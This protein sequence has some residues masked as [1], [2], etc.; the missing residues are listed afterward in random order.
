MK[1]KYIAIAS[2]AAVFFVTS[3]SE[4]YDIYPEEYSKVLRFKDGGLQNITVYSPQDVTE[5]PIVIQKGGTNPSTTATAKVRLMTEEEFSTYLSESGAGYTYLPTNCYS[6]GDGQGSEMTVD[7]AGK[8]GYQKIGVNLYPPK[9]GEFMETFTETNRTP[10]IPLI[11]ES[12][13]MTDEY[14]RELFIAPAYEEPKVSILNG[15]LQILDDGENTYELKIG[16][17]ITSQWNFT[18][19]ITADP[20]ILAEFNKENHTSYSAMPSAAYGQIG[21]FEVKEGDDFATVK[22]NLD[23]AKAEFR[24]ALPLK[25]SSLSIDGFD[26]DDTPCVIAVDNSSEYKLDLTVDDLSSNDVYANDGGGLKSLVDGNPSTHCHGIY[27]GNRT[28]TEPFG[29]WIQI[30]LG[31]ECSRIGIDIYARSTYDN[32]RIKRFYLMAKNPETGNWERFAD[33]DTRDVLTEKGAH[34]AFGSFEAP[35]KFTSI[36]MRIAEADG[37]ELIGTMN[38]FWTMGELVVYGK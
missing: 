16:L 36:V 5:F 26:I 21:Q 38:A 7:F 23:L 29:S 4:T 8:Q 31:K 33:C 19:N 22:V 27:W 12:E 13:A 9:I 1:T 18:G 28:L 2:M 35:F 37:G 11:L 30:K 20:E 34:G 24:T 6:L 14:S 10:V 15:G 17:P 32:G 25:I 3:C